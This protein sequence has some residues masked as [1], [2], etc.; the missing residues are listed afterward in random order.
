MLVFEHMS[1]SHKRSLYTTSLLLGLLVGHV[2]LAQT[3]TYHDGTPCT[4]SQ[5]GQSVTQGQEP[6]V[7]IDGGTFQGTHS[8]YWASCLFSP[9]PTGC[10]GT[11]TTSTTNPGTTTA[12]PASTVPGCA[13]GYTYSITTGAP[14]NPGTAPRIPGCAPGY[15]YSIIT[16]QRCDSTASSGT[17]PS[18]NTTSTGTGASP[19]STGLTFTFGNQTITLTNAAAIALIQQLAQNAGVSSGVTITTTTTGG[20]TTLNGCNLTSANTSDR[21]AEYLR[22]LQGQQPTSWTTPVTTPGT[23]TGMPT[24]AGPVTSYCRPGADQI[25][26]VPWPASGQVRPLTTSFRDQIIAFRITV[27]YANSPLNTPI[28]NPFGSTYNNTHVGFVHI[29]EIP[30]SAVLPR[31]VTVSK[32]PCDFQ[33]G[34]YIT[35]NIG[36]QD[37][38]PGFNYTVNNPTGWYAAGASFNIQSGDTVYVNVRNASWQDYGPTLKCGIDSLRCADILFDFAT[39][40]RY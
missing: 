16:G 10:P 17:T 14:C 12:P 20:G 38:A 28:R 31:D 26:D 33:S 23:T 39:P 24:I 32:N 36:A 21:A 2:A 22:C 3:T 18:T 30:N 25:I 27:P 8:Y 9:K 37:N 6:F 7:C 13:P 35:N 40:N 29:A 1:T 5:L 11:S 34:N 4:A 15:T 19:T